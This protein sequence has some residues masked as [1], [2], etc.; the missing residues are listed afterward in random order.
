MKSKLLWLKL[1]NGGQQTSLGQPSN[2]SDQLP[3]FHQPPISISADDEIMDAA[4]I[5]EGL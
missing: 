5:Y 2:M 3:S 4:D 1:H